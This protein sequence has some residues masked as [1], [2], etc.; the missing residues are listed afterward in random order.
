MRFS[1]LIDM[2]LCHPALLLAVLPALL[3]MLVNGWTDAPVNI[4]TAIHSQ[5]V[6][7]KG[8]ILMSAVCN[9]LGAAVMCA[10]GSS[11]AV[12]VYSISGLD[13]VGSAALPALSAAMTAVA[14]WS[15]F[16]LRFGL[17]TSE[18]HALAAALSG[19]AVAVSGFGALD[20]HEWGKLLLGVL[21]S[22][23]PVAAVSLLA[24]G[25]LRLL[26]LGDGTFK[27]L[28]VTG[29]ALS[30][31]AHGAQDGQKFAGVLTL[32]ATLN[33][34]GTAE[35]TVPLWAVFLSALLI[36]LGTLLGG[37]KII[38][39]F[40]EFAPETPHC[41]FAADLVSAVGLLLLSAAGLPASTTHA[42]SSA[43]FGAGLSE[44]RVKSTKSAILPLIGAWVL[45]FPVSAALGFALTKI[46]GVFI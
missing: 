15:L 3:L 45:T 36:S 33:L 16:A 28:Q 23:V 29:A 43:V 14:V 4:A 5:A 46:F 17:P 31:F 37:R 38:E 2:V 13:K 10:L 21:F 39:R 7:A 9:F 11:V 26:P 35:V 44:R 41:G 8:A 6:S 12:S 18:S 42:K 20:L 22:T 30:S 40:S 19:A 1:E 25:L 32:A 27:K 34:G 24:A